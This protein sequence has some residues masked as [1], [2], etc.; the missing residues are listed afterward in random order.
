MTPS[1]SRGSSVAPYEKKDL[2]QKREEMR[3]IREV[4]LKERVMCWQSSLQ[5]PPPDVWQ[6]AHAPTTFL[7][8]L[9]SLFLSFYLSLCLVLSEAGMCSTNLSLAF[10][11]P[12]SPSQTLLFY[13]RCLSIS[14]SCN[15]DNPVLISSLLAFVMFRWVNTSDGK[16]SKVVW[17]RVEMEA[18]CPPPPAASFSIL[19]Y[20]RECKKNLKPVEFFFFPLLTGGLCD[21]CRWRETD[22][23]PV[24]RP[25]LCIKAQDCTHNKKI[26]GH[27][28]LMN[29]DWLPLKDLRQ[30]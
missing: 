27:A 29:N 22:S 28:L 17:R 24:A 20:S 2:Q 10:K 15:N 9:T 12:P 11:Y 13:H 25:A 8:T 7:H 21:E 4:M 14:T 3:E 18:H 26:L 30:L 5:P 16:V 1:H 6:C 19:P 23:S